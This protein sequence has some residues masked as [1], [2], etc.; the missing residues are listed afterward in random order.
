MVKPRTLETLSAIGY[1]P[2]QENNTIHE[3]ILIIND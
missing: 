3:V 1:N 2:T